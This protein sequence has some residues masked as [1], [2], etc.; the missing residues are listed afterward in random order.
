MSDVNFSLSGFDDL[1]DTLRALNSESAL[2]VGTSAAREG[3]KMVKD[4]FVDAAP[5]GDGP[6]AKTRRTKGGKTVAFDYGH[7]RDNITVRKQRP[8]RE[9]QIKFS[10]GV[11][12]AFWGLFLE[13]GTRFMAARPWLRPAFDVVAPRVID[14]IGRLL[15]IGIEREAKRLNRKAKKLGR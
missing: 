1:T 2:K 8:E 9:H 4:A 6:T 5:V 10:V 3:G 14:A 7:L 11:G 13:F 12:A 15:G